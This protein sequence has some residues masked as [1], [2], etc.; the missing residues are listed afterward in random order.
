M[1]YGTR[2]KSTYVI[3]ITGHP[4]TGKTTLAHWL[5]QELELPLIWKDQIKETL[6]E[7]FGHSTNEWSRKLSEASW[8]L[9]YQWV[10]GLLR[11]N[12][13]HIVESNFS[14]RHANAHWQTLSKQYTF[15]VVQIRCE[16]RA[17]LLLQRYRRRIEDGDRHSGHVDACTD[18]SFL[19]AIQRP[20]GWIAVKSERISF[21][22]TS[23]RDGDYL[24]LADAIR[25]LSLS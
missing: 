22:T 6:L 4:A 8:T 18:P 1:I 11:A 15:S 16:T 13:S 25:N 14:P 20:M 10:E 12:V 7:R 24:A 21:D 17:D 2:E 9:L 3:V 5:A 23:V 19:E